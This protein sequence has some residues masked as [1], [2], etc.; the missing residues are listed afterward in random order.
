MLFNLN[1]SE[2]I[3]GVLF[4]ED[5]V[6]HTAGLRQQYYIQNKTFVDK[7]SKWED[8]TIANTATLLPLLLM[9]VTE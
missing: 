8:I 7:Q 5:L 4:A 3:A 6:L 9:D 2:F 1:G